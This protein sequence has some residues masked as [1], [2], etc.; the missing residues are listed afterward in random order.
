MTDPQL[1]VPLSVL[2]DVRD[3]GGEGHQVW[4][5]RLGC[6]YDHVRN[7]REEAV[8]AAIQHLA[9]VHDIRPAGE[10][11]VL[12][13]IVELDDWFNSGDPTVIPPADAWS[14]AIERARELCNNKEI[15]T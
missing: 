14:E 10:R 5:C 1:L 2:V 7:T 11:E 3:F 8:S 12:R 6:R 9:E 15:S 4:S 13:R